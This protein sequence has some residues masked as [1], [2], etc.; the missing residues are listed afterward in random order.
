MKR[1]SDIFSV[2]PSDADLGRDLGV[3]YP[4]VSAWKQRGSIPATYW[5]D[6]IRAARKRGHPEITAD[7][8]V[9]LH[10]R[11]SAMALVGFEEEEGPFRAGGDAQDEAPGTKPEATGHFLRFKHPRV[12]YFRSAAEI[13]EYV[14]K[15]RDE[16]SHR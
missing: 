8:L 14:N 5:R 6:I 11:E 3:S 4:T 15:L 13:E 7:V 16:W 1:V 12:D 9:D 2:W 10:A